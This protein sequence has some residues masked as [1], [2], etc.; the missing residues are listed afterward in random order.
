MNIKYEGTATTLAKKL[1][2]SKTPLTTKSGESI[3]QQFQNSKSKEETYNQNTSKKKKKKK[4]EPT[5][6]Q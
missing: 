4:T 5:K 2:T 1:L 3:N 6:S